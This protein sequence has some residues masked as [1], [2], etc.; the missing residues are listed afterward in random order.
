MCSNKKEGAG[1]GETTQ[2]QTKTEQ[3]KARLTQLNSTQLKP[4]KPISN[5]N[6]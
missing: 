4:N 1:G 3:G 5:K 6:T 2:I